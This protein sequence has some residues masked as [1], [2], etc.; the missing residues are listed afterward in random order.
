MA[1]AQPPY[2][3][4]EQTVLTGSDNMPKA[5]QVRPRRRA[6]QSLVVHTIVQ[7][8]MLASSLWFLTYS[9]GTAVSGFSWVDVSA[10][11]NLMLFAIFLIVLGVFMVGLDASS[12]SLLLLAILPVSSYSLLGQSGVA[13]DLPIQPLLVLALFR[14]FPKALRINLRLM[15]IVSLFCLLILASA[16]VAR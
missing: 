10:G 12:Q 14:L 2:S 3:R 6:G 5:P 16:I 8:L 13:V 7:A 11:H 15:L 4:L 9:K 1:V